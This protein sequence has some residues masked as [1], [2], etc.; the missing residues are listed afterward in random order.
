V[1]APGDTAR[2][3]VDTVFAVKDSMI[4]YSASYDLRAGS[5]PYRTQEHALLGFKVTKLWRR[6]PLFRMASTFEPSAPLP[7]GQGPFEGTMLS[8]ATYYNGDTVRTE[9]SITRD[10]LNLTVNQVKK[11][12]TTSYEVAMDAAGNLLRDPCLSPCLDTNV[13]PRRAARP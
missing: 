1:P 9:G 8:V 4:T 3:T 11:G 10:S 2:M 5:A 6:G 12:I 7:M 13:S